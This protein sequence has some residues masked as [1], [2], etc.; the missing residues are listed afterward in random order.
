MLELL[1]HPLYAACL[2]KQSSCIEEDRWSKSSGSRWRRSR[3]PA[4][5]HN[6]SLG[7]PAAGCPDAPACCS[8]SPGVSSYKA[9]KQQQR[10]QHQH[11]QQLQHSLRELQLGQFINSCHIAKID[12]NDLYFLLPFTLYFAPEPSASTFSHPF[13]GTLPSSPAAAACALSSLSSCKYFYY[14][15]LSL[16][17]FTASAW[18]CLLLL[19]LLFY[20]LS[21]H[22]VWSRF[23]R[24]LL[25]FRFRCLNWTGSSG[26]L[27]Q[28]GRQ[29]GRREGSA[30]LLWSTQ[31]NVLRL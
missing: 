12:C 29:A 16:L 13:P 5:L 30:N 15:I 2:P 1:L 31:Y 10:A 6:P 27:V 21:F 18:H 11:Q 17:V 20:T 19:L 28:G 24:S 26:F 23:S 4:P 14:N 9:A 3:C 8:Y 22:F 25:S 7:A